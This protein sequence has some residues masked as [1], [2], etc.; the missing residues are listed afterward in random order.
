MTRS[1]SAYD[2]F[3]LGQLNKW[4]LEKRER[5]EKDNY[6]ALSIQESRDE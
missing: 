3:L 6:E 4:E 5:P 2:A 1:E